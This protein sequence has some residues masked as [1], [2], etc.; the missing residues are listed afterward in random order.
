MLKGK[1]GL[2]IAKDTKFREG[3]T[4]QALTRT[5]EKKKLKNVGSHQQVSDNNDVV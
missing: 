4:G 1:R 5:E 3:P 2:Q